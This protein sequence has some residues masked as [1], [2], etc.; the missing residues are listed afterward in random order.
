[1]IHLAGDLKILIN[2]DDVSRGLGVLRLRAS[3]E[4]SCLWRMRS[5]DAQLRIRVKRL[6]TAL[7]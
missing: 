7:E 2:G 3:E 6:L 1:M 5:G 4:G